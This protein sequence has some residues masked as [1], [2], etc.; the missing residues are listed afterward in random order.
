MRKELGKS[1]GQ[2]SH[3]T[4]YGIVFFS[5]IAWEAGDEVHLNR[6]GGNAT[7]RV[8]GGKNTGGRKPG[9]VGN[10]MGSGNAPAG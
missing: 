5:C 8:P 7:V 6:Q 3:G 9:E 10:L 4:R 2:L 1:I